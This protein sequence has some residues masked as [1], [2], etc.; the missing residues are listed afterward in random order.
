MTLAVLCLRA[1][2]SCASCYLSAKT[3]VPAAGG[4]GCMRRDSLHSFDAPVSVTMQ[5]THHGRPV[6]NDLLHRIF[7]FTSLGKRYTAF[8]VLIC[9]VRH[10]QSIRDPFKSIVEF[11]LLRYIPSKP[12]ETAP[13]SSP[14]QL[15]SLLYRPIPLPPPYPC[16]V[17]ICPFPFP[18]PSST[19]L[20]KAGP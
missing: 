8:E 20:P 2:F 10:A 17:R 6:N 9:F 13:H 19:S 18:S 12:I 7:D 3:V 5:R 15:P 14:F 1:V 11:Q 4:A 16:S